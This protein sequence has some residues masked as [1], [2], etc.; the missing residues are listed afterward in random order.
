MRGT[1]CCCWGQAGWCWAQELH[2]YG[3][4]CSPGVRPPSHVTVL[5][6][7]HRKNSIPTKEEPVLEPAHD[8][9]GA[10]PRVFAAGDG[11]TADG[12]GCQQL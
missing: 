2:P 5:S 7:C 9:W 10:F 11:H 1:T 8:C 4:S 6:L 3:F 12:W